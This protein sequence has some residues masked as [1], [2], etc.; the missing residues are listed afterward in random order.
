MEDDK[1]TLIKRLKK[2]SLG[3]LEEV[4]RNTPH[5]IIEN[6]EEIFSQNWA[7]I[8]FIMP[9]LK[10]ISPDTDA[11]INEILQKNI[12]DI[13]HNLL[14]QMTEIDESRGI[15][16]EE[17]KEI[18]DK[19]YMTL[20][21]LPC[22]I[23][24]SDKMSF[25]D[26]EKIGSGCYTNVYKVGHKIFKIGT[27]RET[28][29]IPNHKRILQPLLRR[30][31][32]ERGYPCAFIEIAEEVKTGLGYQDYKLLYNLYKELRDDGI[33]W[34]DPKLENV[35]WLKRENI[36]MLHGEILNVDT[37]S[38]GFKQSLRCNPLNK[39]ELVILD[40]D[41][42][43]EENS[44]CIETNNT[45]KKFE[46]IYQREKWIKEEVEENIKS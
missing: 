4:A 32:P 6:L 38:L 21:I 19:Y 30:S 12:Q 45:A 10:G 5:L 17:K 20:A 18:A 7:D 22:E 39:G 33:I 16:K 34:G 14:M 25:V 41:Y 28:A 27:P 44:P 36:P 42:I 29:V 9:V 46:E 11:R 31:L 35:G 26:I 3:K 15:T 37:K 24:K 8:F 2:C 43:Y 13:S 23:L 40:T 1:N